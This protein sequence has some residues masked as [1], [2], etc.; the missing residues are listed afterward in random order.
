MNEEQLAKFNAIMMRVKQEQTQFLQ[1]ANAISTKELGAEAKLD[2][3][4]KLVSVKNE[5]N[6]QALI[7]LGALVDLPS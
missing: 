3:I 7:E 6:A 1:Q 2:A 5:Q 4:N